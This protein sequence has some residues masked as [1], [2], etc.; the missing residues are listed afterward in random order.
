MCCNSA[1]IIADVSCCRTTA[2]CRDAMLSNRMACMLGMN[3]TICFKSS[4]PADI[5]PDAEE[6]E[7]RVPVEMPDGV[8][9][10]SSCSAAGVPH[11]ASTS[12][13]QAPASVA[14]EAGCCA[15][16]LCWPEAGAMPSNGCALVGKGF[17]PHVSLA[18]SP[19]EFIVR[20]TCLPP[21]ASEL[22]EWRGV[23]AAPRARLCSSIPSPSHAFLPRTFS[24]SNARVTRPSSSRS[25]S[26]FMA[27]S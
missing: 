16:M 9:V 5:F 19:N 27:V 21:P 7:P 15:H 17:R 25:R 12:G 14:L 4:C 18:G 20:A 22:I 8:G 11:V 10:G 26:H 2:A 6:V 3:S 24:P 23:L 13:R 1:A